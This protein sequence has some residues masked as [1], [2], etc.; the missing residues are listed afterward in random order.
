MVA[1]ELREKALGSRT[2]DG[3]E[4]RYEI[5][6]VH[7]DSGVRDSDGLRLFIELEV[8]ARGIDAVADQGLVG[9]VGEDEVA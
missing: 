2:G 4:I 7:A 1:R 8:D 3:S 5:F 6:L 9:V